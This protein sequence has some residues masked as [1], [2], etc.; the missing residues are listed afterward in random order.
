LFCVT[1]SVAGIETQTNIAM[2]LTKP[3]TS[4]VVE[5]YTSILPSP[6]D[7][8]NYKPDT[9]PEAV[10]SSTGY[11]DESEISANIGG[12]TVVRTALVVTGVVIGCAIWRGLILTK[13]VKRLRK[14]P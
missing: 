6:A 13:M 11:K 7:D 8:I 3:V 10:N 12:P 4:E 9:N 1:G 2:C 14:I 5:R